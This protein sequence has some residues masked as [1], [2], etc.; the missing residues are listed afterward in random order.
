MTAATTSRLD[1]PRTRRWTRKEYYRLVNEGFFIG[2]RAELLYG[3]IIEMSPQN[4]PHAEAIELADAFVRRAFPNAHRIRI[5]SP[6]KLK[7]ISEPEPDLAIVPGKVG[8]GADHPSTAVLIIEVADTSLQYD[9]R[10]ARLYARNGIADYWIVNLADRCIEIHRDPLADGG[11]RGGPA[12]K[13]M[14]AYKADESISPLAAP[15]ASIQVQDLLP[16]TP[17]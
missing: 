9:R 6:L 17:R 15:T 3:R 10:K 7:P 12:Y 16:R 14:Q 5:Q 11:H 4:Y 2:Q 8:E 13:S 1:R